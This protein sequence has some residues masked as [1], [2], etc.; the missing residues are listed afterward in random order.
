MVIFDITG[1]EIT[2]LVEGS[3][4]AGDHNLTWNADN[5]SSGICIWG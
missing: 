4:K 2:K 1:R 5:Q 3:M